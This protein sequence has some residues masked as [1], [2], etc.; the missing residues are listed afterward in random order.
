MVM[1]DQRKLMETDASSFLNAWKPLTSV[2]S[3]VDHP[4]VDM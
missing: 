3:M 2:H 4:A 1:F